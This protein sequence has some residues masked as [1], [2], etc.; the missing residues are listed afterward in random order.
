MKLTELRIFLVASVVVFLGGLCLQ[1]SLFHHI[2]AARQSPSRQA[3]LLPSTIDKS[4]SQ[5][6]AIRQQQQ[7][8]PLPAVPRQSSIQLPQ[9]NPP[10]QR[11]VVPPRARGKCAINLYGLPRAFESLVLPSLVKNVLQGEYLF[12]RCRVDWCECWRRRS[13][14]SRTKIDNPRFWRISQQSLVMCPIPNNNSQCRVPMRLLCP[15]LQPNAR[16]FGAIR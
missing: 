16:G 6:S 14:V 12:G 2:T 13:G 15:L 5:Y 9:A 8:H 7:Q 1:L 4:K 11:V 3:T 10:P